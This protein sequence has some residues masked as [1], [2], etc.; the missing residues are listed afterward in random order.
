MRKKDGPIETESH[1]V[2]EARL[3]D[4]VST[5]SVPPWRTRNFDFYVTAAHRVRYRRSLFHT[6]SVKFAELDGQRL[7]PM[8]LLTLF[9][10]FEC[11]LPERKRT[12]Q[13]GRDVTW[14]DFL[15]VRIFTGKI[16]ISR[17]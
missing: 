8:L 12:I 11:V 9:F 6:S 1:R 7:R 5:V 16:P 3:S 15:V 14:H 2:P 4:V 13:E 10:S 17:L